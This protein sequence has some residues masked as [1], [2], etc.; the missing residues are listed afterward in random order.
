MDADVFEHGRLFRGIFTLQRIAANFEGTA[1]PG[2]DCGFNPGKDGCISCHKL[3]A[4]ELGS[5]GQQLDRGGMSVRCLIK[6][7]N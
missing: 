6:I 7:D 4:K 3:S 2:E 5:T 1:I